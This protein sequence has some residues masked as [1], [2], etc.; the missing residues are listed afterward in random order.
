VVLLNSGV[1]DLGNTPVVGLTLSYDFS[2]KRERYYMPV[3]YVEA[4]KA[5]GGIPFLLPSVNDDGIVKA[6]LERVDCLVLSGGCDI[7]PQYFGEQP[8]PGLGDV[9][10]LRDEFEFRLVSQALERKVPILGICRGMQVLVAATGGSLYQD[11]EFQVDKPLQHRQKAPSWAGT[12]RIDVLEGTRLCSILGC[13]QI[14]VNSFH[15]QAVSETG[16][17]FIVSATSSDGVVEAI[18]SRESDVFVLGVQWH[19]ELMWQRE[20]VFL[21]L[22]KDLTRSVRMGKL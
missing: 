15:H 9:D 5:V 1:K 2:I 10:P 3:E 13:N 20:A 17:C 18:E 4:V 19:P 7:D 21:R 8:L 14:R 16:P 6:F 22:F 12:H 11:I